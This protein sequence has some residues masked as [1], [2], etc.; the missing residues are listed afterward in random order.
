MGIAKRANGL[1]RAGYY[2]KGNCT[3]KIGTAPRLEKP[4]P[5]RDWP[6]KENIFGETIISNFGY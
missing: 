6:G 3:N 2:R 5:E 4:Y 1:W